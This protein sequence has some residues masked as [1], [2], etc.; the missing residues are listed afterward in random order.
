MPDIFMGIGTSR[1]RDEDEASCRA[2]GQQEH[3]VGTE[4]MLW[5]HGEGSK[6]WSPC[7]HPPVPLQP[8]LPQRHLCVPCQHLEGGRF[9]SPVHPQEAKALW[10]QSSVTGSP[11]PARRAICL[12]FCPSPLRGGWPRRAGPRPEPSCA[13]TP[14][15]RRGGP[16][17]SL[18]SLPGALAGLELTTGSSPTHPPWSG[19]S[20][21]GGGRV[22]RCCPP[23]PAPWP[24]PGPHLPVRAAPEPVGCGNS[25]KGTSR[26]VHALEHPQGTVSSSVPSLGRTLIRLNTSKER[27]QGW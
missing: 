24:R 7:I 16:G 19:P 1:C 6:P 14:A 2:K 4:M 10:G 8:G 18:L 12:S 3:R 11:G 21:A 27:Q 26:A 20:E 25:G 23:S 13:D 22:G 15:W 17:C 5:R 9:P